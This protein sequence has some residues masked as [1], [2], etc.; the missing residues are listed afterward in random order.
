MAL[1][2]H[3]HSLSVVSMEHKQATLTYIVGKPYDTTL[4]SLRAAL[5]T[6]G[7]EIPMEMDISGAIRREFGIAL[8]A[9]SFLYVCCPFL[10]LEAFVMDT[11]CTGFLPLQVAVSETS[12]QTL[13]SLLEPPAV[14]ETELPFNV[15]TPMMRLQ[16]RVQKIVKSLEEESGHHC[17]QLDHLRL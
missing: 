17:P 15:R 8:K 12:G 14:D 10:L 13:I 1:F 9:C 3:K 2:V 5:K 4:R 16:T 6:E 7:L 11:P